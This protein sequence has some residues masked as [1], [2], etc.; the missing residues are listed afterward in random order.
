MERCNSYIVICHGSLT[1]TT[2]SR[3]TKSSKGF[4]SELLTNHEDMSTRSGRLKTST[5]Q[6]GVTRHAMVIIIDSECVRCVL[7]KEKTDHFEDMVSEY[8]LIQQLHND[9]RF[10]T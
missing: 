7:I 5:T 3:F 8:K 10:T 9:L 1:T 6:G 2:S 4:A